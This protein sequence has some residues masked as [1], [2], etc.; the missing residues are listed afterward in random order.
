MNFRDRFSEYATLKSMGFGR[1]TIFGMVQSEALLLCGLGGLIGV[2]VPYIAFTHTPLRNVT[3][4]LIQTLEI[5]PVVCLVGI[6]V[7]LAI[8]VLAALWPA[9]QALRLNVVSAL[10]A[11][12]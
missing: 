9:W 1:R 5:R 11:L 8:G 7:S 2:A 4:P 6:G 10:R 12:E 3:I